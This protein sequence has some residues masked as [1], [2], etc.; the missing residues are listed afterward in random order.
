M[1]TVGT[2]RLSTIA[3]V[4]SLG[5]DE[6][7]RLRAVLLADEAPAPEREALLRLLDDVSSGRLPLAEEASVL[8]ASGT[9]HAADQSVPSLA[10][11]ETHPS[12]DEEVLRLAGIERWDTHLGQPPSGSGRGVPD[13]PSG[14]AREPTADLVAH[15][16]VRTLVEDAAGSLSEL[17]VSPEMAGVVQP[18]VVLAHV[19]ADLGRALARLAERTMLLELNVARLTGGLAGASG[20]ERYQDFIAQMADQ[21][22]QQRVWEEYPV[23][24]RMLVAVRDGQVEASRRLLHDLAADRGDIVDVL[25]DGRDPGELVEIQAHQGDSHR[26]GRTV[27]VLR[28]E[29][30]RRLVYKPRSLAVDQHFRVLVEHLND[31]TAGL[32]LRSPAVL[33]RGDHG[34]AE[35]VEHAPCTSSS[36]VRGYFRRAG[37]LLAL[38]HTL[39]ATDVHRE[40]IVAVGEYPVVVDLESL[41]HPPL[42]PRPNRPPAEAA[43]HAILDDSVLATGLLPAPLAVGVDLSGLS[44]PS[45]QR[46]PHTVLQ[47]NNPGRDD[48][49]YVRRPTALGPAQNVLTLDGR[50]VDP[51][52][53]VAEVVAG[54]RAGYD[55]LQRVR[56]ELLDDAGPLSG[57][58][59]DTTRV[60]LRATQTYGLLLQQCSHPDV[61][62]DS[63][64]RDRVLARLGSSGS[65]YP[66]PIV[67]AEM[68]D[69]RRADI[70][71]FTTSPTSMQVLTADGEPVSGVVAE[72]AMGA[73]RRRIAGLEPDDRRR[74]EWIVHS[75]LVSSASTAAAP[76][77]ARD[78]EPLQA[79][80]PT[81][82]AVEIGQRLRELAFP[83]G[84]GPA[85]LTL[86]RID[87]SA[88][89]MQVCGEDLYGG[90][91]GIAYFLLYLGEVTGDSTATRLARTVLESAV[92]HAS[93]AA[94]GL[95]LHTG[96]AG[97]VHV[98]THAGV[99]FSDD[100]LLEE[101]ERLAVTMETLVGTDEDLD[102]LDGS[103]G[104]ILGVRALYR[105]RSSQRLLDLLVRCGERLVDRATEQPT[106]VGWHVRLAPAVPLAGLAHGAAGIAWALLELAEL[107]GNQEFATTAWQGIGYERTLFSAER[108]NWRDLR[109]D[110]VGDP[111]SG[112]DDDRV[113]GRAGDKFMA[114]WC[115]GAPG[116]GLARFAVRGAA[117]DPAVDQE[118]RTALDTTVRVGFGGNH[119]LCHGDLGN[120]E[121]LL[122]AREVGLASD[123]DVQTQVHAVL[124]GLRR[125]PV[126]GLPIPAEVPG[127][128]LGLAGMGLSLLRAADSAV[129][130]I[131]VADPPQ[132]E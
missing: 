89:T 65:A 117:A 54:F 45:G 106:G 112:S 30:G 2:G 25:L 28:F 50:R 37:A 114:S 115:H 76:T 80:D 64:S 113:D 34:W 20:E 36:Q 39:R 107:T 38:L 88:W 68:A 58:V 49:H 51:A 111:L 43:L 79:A 109:T 119:S 102:V 101:A 86:S 29:D 81:P 60:V 77:W 19:R 23:L 73:L 26:G 15:T 123:Q 56:A 127:L 4:R 108:G 14:E 22:A 82:A 33:D 47:W 129:P 83:T 99:V 87:E 84:D 62:H 74:Q 42:V 120:L 71:A 1:E 69:L 130:S 75:S 66:T 27:S 9:S 40:N 92:K 32:T 104:C 13:P 55:L 72:P 124:A 90:V 78:D 96:R 95:G 53:H 52:D 131:L 100:S 7:D 8:A 18:P 122:R 44:G 67:A 24:A 70:P 11:G 48:W 17:A 3:F 110:R 116:I 10:L 57:F 98:L 5:A 126:C 93:A 31:L 97:L 85:W 6:R 94:P 63:A 121:L 16:L 61:L 35:F 91:P 132:T 12:V 59:D 125:Q 105:V 21:H 41:L 118:I 128:M 46:T 103:A